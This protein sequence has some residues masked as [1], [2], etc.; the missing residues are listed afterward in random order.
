[1][2][3]LGIKANDSKQ[4]QKLKDNKDTTNSSSDIRDANN[5]DNINKNLSN[6]QKL[7]NQII[8]LSPKFQL[9]PKNQIWQKP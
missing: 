3:F 8:W 2:S 9:N 6:Y 5:I 4:N 7:E 1:M